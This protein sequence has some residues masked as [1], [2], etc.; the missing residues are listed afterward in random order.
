MVVILRKGEPRSRGEN[1]EGPAFRP[2]PRPF[3]RQSQ[4]LLQHT[5]SVSLKQVPY[6]SNFPRSILP[7]FSPVTD[8]QLTVTITPSHFI[9]LS[10][11]ASHA[12]LHFT[13]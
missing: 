11:I 3:T 4:R 2:N 1:D 12:S 8:T 6:S 9:W 13:F 5:F 10:D 7:P